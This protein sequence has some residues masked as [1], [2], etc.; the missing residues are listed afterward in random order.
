VVLKT[1]AN[2]GRL[3][4]IRNPAVAWEHTEER[5]KKM[6]RLMWGCL[7]KLDFDHLVMI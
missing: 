3:E 6:E 1:E 5:D 4:K 2:R 7:Q